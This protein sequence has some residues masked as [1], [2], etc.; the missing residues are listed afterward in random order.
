MELSEHDGSARMGP[1]FGGEYYTNMI[2]THLG[3][4]KYFLFSNDGKWH[5]GSKGGN[6]HF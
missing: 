1:T 5:Q 4:D 2:Y 3:T 6:S